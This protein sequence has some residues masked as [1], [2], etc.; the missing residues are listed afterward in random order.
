V[1]TKPIPVLTKTKVL[2]L[3]RVTSIHTLD[4]K[5][6]ILFYDHLGPFI[7]IWCLHH[8]WVAGID[9]VSYVSPPRISWISSSVIKQWCTPPCDRIHS[10]GWGR[11]V[12][13]RNKCNCCARLW[14]AWATA[15]QSV[16][17]VMGWCCS[18]SFRNQ[19]CYAFWIHLSIYIY[20]WPNDVQRMCSTTMS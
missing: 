11:K 1:S 9:V 19:G 10:S 4:D 2:I 17:T 15:Q 13:S 12:H 7:Q 3:G 8:D 5:T 14:R 20:N 16:I 6:V 18:L